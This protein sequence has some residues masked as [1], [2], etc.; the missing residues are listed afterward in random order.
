MKQIAAITAF[1]TG[2]DL[3]AAENI[4]AWVENP[5]IE[6]AGSMR[7][8]NSVLLF[9][10]KYDAVISIER[11][12]HKVHPVELLFAHLT[13]WLMD[14]DGE[15]S[16]GSEAVI[17]NEVDVLDDSTADIVLTIDFIEDV[18]AIED[19]AGPIAL[20]GKTYKLADADI[21]YAETGGVVAEAA[22]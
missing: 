6:A 21:W 22:A 11:F 19:A 8:A 15:R 3:V 2:L 5:Q 9:R 14:N 13:T 4:D 10:Q 18:T 12:P 1:L 17:Q 20:A 16:D 7:G